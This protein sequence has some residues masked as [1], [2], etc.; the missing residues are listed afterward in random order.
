[1]HCHIVTA[2]KNGIYGIYSM[3]EV[4]EYTQFWAKGSGHEL[5]LGAMHYA[6]S[7]C[8]HAEE[9]ARAGVEA[10]IIY[11]QALRIALHLLPYTVSN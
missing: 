7:R 8:G 5:S 1:M 10:G 4:F 9:I 6:Y 11:G 3:R 2:R